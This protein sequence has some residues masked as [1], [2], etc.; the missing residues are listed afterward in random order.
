MKYKVIEREGKEVLAEY[1]D[2]KAAQLEMTRRVRQ[3]LVDGAYEPY[4]YAIVD[5]ADNVID[6]Q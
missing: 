1:D 5:E 6:I 4:F 2:L 3:D